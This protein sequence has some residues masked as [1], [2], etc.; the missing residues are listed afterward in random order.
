MLSSALKRRKCE[1]IS[2]CRSVWVTPFV[3]MQEGYL[4]ASVLLRCPY[5]VDRT[6]QSNS[7]VT[8]QI[9]GRCHVC[10]LFSNEEQNARNVVLYDAI[11]TC[12]LVLGEHFF[13]ISFSSRPP[14]PPPTSRPPSRSVLI[15]CTFGHR[16]NVIFPRVC[17]L[18]GTVLCT[19]QRVRV[20]MCVCV[21]DCVLACV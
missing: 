16:R 10:S 12:T 1:T 2:S 5:P 3:C 15:I 13:S 18:K 14:N 7:Y 20:C 8:E 21:R 9:S 17:T 6:L 11:D 4:F 19:R